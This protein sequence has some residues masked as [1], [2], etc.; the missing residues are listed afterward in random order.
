MVQYPIDGVPLVP[1]PSQQMR[2]AI[3]HLHHVLRVQVLVDVIA[4]F[5]IACI[6]RN[7]IDIFKI[8]CT[9]LAYENRCI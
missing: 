4:I 5:M 2:V 3:R 9:Q 7:S 8:N 6:W 1:V